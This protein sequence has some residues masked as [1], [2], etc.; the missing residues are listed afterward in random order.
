MAT[1]EQGVIT[2]FLNYLKFEKRYSAHTIRSYQDDLAE[3]GHFLLQEFSTLIS[4]PATITTG[5]V[6]TWL[7]QLK[8]SGK[9]ARTI[10]RKISSLK[11]F[12]K[13]QM[14]SGLMEKTPMAGIISPKI[15][16]RLP[17]YVKEEQMDTL[18]RHVAFPDTW[19]GRTD[20]LILAIL[21][22]T[23]MRRA[24]LLNLRENQVNMAGSSIKVLGKGNKERIIPVSKVLVAA[25]REYIDAKR[26]SFEEVDTQILLV[27]EKGKKL[28]PEYIYKVV[29]KYLSTVTTLEKKSP[30]VL[31]HTFATHL[32]GNGAE[33]NAVK[34]LLGHASLS[35]TQIY[36]HNTLNKLKEVYKKAHP[37]A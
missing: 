24:E 9:S 28:Y 23:G 27:G 10:N 3:F 7:A 21:Y 25:I 17:N 8:E 36:T 22:N 6:R 26:S 31:R 19:A 1:V 4:S 34:E 11:S 14:R 5:M 29:K 18:L 32:T 35:A 20:W 33:L 13:Y 15:A 2:A 37:K 12:F 16:K 30:H